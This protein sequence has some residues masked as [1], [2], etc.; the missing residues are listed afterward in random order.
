MEN[1]VSSPINSIEDS[2]RL[3]IA[4]M[5]DW[6]TSHYRTFMRGLTQHTLLYTEM[7]TTGAILF[8]D[9]ERHLRFNEIEQ[10]VAM[11]LGGSDPEALAKC[12]KICEDRGYNEINLNVGCPSDRVQNGSFGAC[13]MAEPKLVGDCIKAMQDVVDIPVTVKSRIGIDN[14][15][16]YE[17]FQDFIGTVNHIS[18]CKTFIVHARKAI[19]KGLSP[20]ENREIPPLKYDY[21]YRIKEQFP[22]FHISLNGGVK[23][24]E[25]AEAHLTKVDGVMIGREAYNNPYLFAAADQRIFGDNAA[26]QATRHEAI[27]SLYPYVEAE[28]ERGTY[29]NHIARHML[30]MFQAVPGARKFR[31][32]ISE[33][34]TKPGAGL[35]VLIDALEMV[36]EQPVA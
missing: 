6:T 23:T 31:R 22:D 7:V 30:G 28:L 13:L 2:R 33:N 27:R 11:Q 5:L 20:K 14:Q 9:Q 36:T 16:S 10:N 4:P 19:L 24:L 21:V 12:A 34:A 15:D 26:T 3:S 17:E 35:E 29:L 25:E 8:G 18:Q 32:H 1:K